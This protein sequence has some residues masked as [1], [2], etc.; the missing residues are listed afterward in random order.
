MIYTDTHLH[1]SFSSDSTADM[2][3]MIRKGI[4]LGL[5]TICFTEHYD[6]D[7]PD[8]PEG[9]DFLPDFDTY[10]KTCSRLSLKYADRIEVL[11][12]IEL[13]I[14]PHLGGELN[15]FTEEYGNRYDFIIGSTHLINRMDPY[16]PLFFDSLGPREGLLKYFETTYENLLIF[17]G[18]QSVGH[19]DYAARYMK[20]PAPIFHYDDY[21]EILDK[22][23]MLIINNDK[24]L[25]IN[26]SGLKAGLDWP[27][28]HMEILKRYRALGGSRITIGSDAHTPEHMAYDFHRLPDIM[29]EAGFDHY[30]LYRR[31]KACRIDI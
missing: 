19:L 28:P 6:P 2:E 23:L 13:G 5:K 25:E 8:N 17:N 1:T 10:Y 26:T 11:H 7:F 21:A 4:R 24:A 20:K 27:N 12:G 16:D 29:R 22:I 3:S 9:L 31:Q 30:E 14:Q 18:Y 15:H